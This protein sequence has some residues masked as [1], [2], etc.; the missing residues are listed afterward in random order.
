MNTQ[1]LIYIGTGAAL[2]Y[3]FFK[4]TKTGANLIKSVL[5]NCQVITTPDNRTKLVCGSTPCPAGKHLETDA[6]GVN[7]CV[8][9]VCPDGQKNLVLSNGTRQCVP[10]DTLLVDQPKRFQLLQPYMA[11]WVNPTS[12]LQDN[13]T[14]FAQGDYVDG[15]IQKYWSAPGD[16][17]TEFLRIVTRTDGTLPHNATNTGIWGGEITLFIPADVVTEVQSLQPVVSPISSIPSETV[18][19]GSTIISQPAPYNPAVVNPAF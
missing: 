7:T 12:P 13:V 6:N 8:P 3:L 2:V 9:D 17:P 11:H 15:Y 16:V 5:P 14:S 10:V 19:T 18:N 4:Y 1:K